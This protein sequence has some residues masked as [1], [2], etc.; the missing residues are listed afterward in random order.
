MKN[1]VQAGENITVEAASTVVSG[2]GHKV[3][4]LFGVA[5]GNAESGADVVLSTT[6]VFDM[7][8]VGADDIA[9][10]AAIYWKNADSLVT[11][12]ASG[13]TKIGV[14]IA[15]ADDTAASVRVRLNGSF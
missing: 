14:A 3:G 12:S 9:L 8:K 2:Q 4:S 1:Y 7:A 10:G 13:N 15:A 11:T 6:G 5:N